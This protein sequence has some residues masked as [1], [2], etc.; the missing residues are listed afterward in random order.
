MKIIQILNSPNWSAASS[1]CIGVSSELKRLGHDVLL[2]TEPGKPLERA[3]ELGIPFDDTIRLNHR[4]LFLYIQA[5][6]RMKTIFQEFQPDI[7]SAHMN[8]GAWMA[9]MIAKRYVPK[10]VVARIRTDIAAPKS[11]FINRYVHH[12]WTDYIIVGSEQ[13]K[14]ICCKNL[15][16]PADKISVVYGCVDADKFKPASINLK[17]REEIGVAADDFLIGFLGRLS[18]IKGHEYALK[19]VSMLTDLPKQVKLLCIGYESERTAQWLKE[20]AARLGMS[21]RLRWV[22]RRDDLPEI[23]N[24]LDIG[25]ISS[26]GSEANSRATLEYM[27]SGLPVVGTSVGVIPEIIA[28]NE[29]GF[30]VAPGNAEA[31]CD[32]IKKLVLDP[33]LCKRMGEASRKRIE[34]HFTLQR[35]G[36]IM[37]NVYKGLVKK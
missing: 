15:D 4:N 2:L 25:I 18:P 22:G 33:E 12:K 35:F 9:G 26:L 19:A 27:A 10:A 28:D 21:D 37:E 11:H 24:S 5:M 29:T 8:E 31:M 14:Q 23:L 17:V 7:I 6:K 32:A 34:E 36:S 30:V 13:H 3:K 20:E 16:Y 1:Y